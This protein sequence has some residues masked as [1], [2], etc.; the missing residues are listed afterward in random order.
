MDKICAGHTSFPISTAKSTAPPAY[1]MTE[2]I[3]TLLAFCFCFASGEP[4]GCAL[5]KTSRKNA[6][7]SVS[8]GMV[9]Q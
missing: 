7:G 6:S 2:G 8:L 9:C 3:R 5:K 4:T 1:A